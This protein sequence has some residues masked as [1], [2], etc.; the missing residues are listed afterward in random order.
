[1]NE[2]DATTGASNR[3]WHGAL[4][5]AHRHGLYD[6]SPD[7]SLAGVPVEQWS[8]VPPFVAYERRTK[9]L[10]G[11]ELREALRPWVEFSRSEGVGTVLDFSGKHASADVDYIYSM[12]G[13]RSKVPVLWNSWRPDTQP[14]PAAMILP[15]EREIGPEA[16]EAARAFLAV[17]TRQYT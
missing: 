17:G 8:E 9:W 1:M 12:F 10:F 13:V 14:A 15:D 2:E 6:L 16:A 4:V 11:D 7:W 5:D 3:S